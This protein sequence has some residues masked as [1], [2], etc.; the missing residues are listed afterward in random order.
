[1]FDYAGA[2]HV[3]TSYSYDGTTGLDEI[4]RAARRQGLDFIVVTDHFRMDARRDGWEGWH[5]DVLVI[6]GEEISPRHNHYLALNIETPVIHWRKKARAQD[7]IDEVNRQGGIG[8]IAHP[9]H[10][11][12]PGYGVKEYA[13]TDW[14]ATGYAGI[15]IWDFMTDWQEK[16][17]S[18]GAAVMAYLFPALNLSGPKQATLS[19]WDALCRTRKVA[20]YGEI[21]NHNS[22]KK[23]FGITFR[24]FPFDVAFNTIR[25]HVLLED[26]LSRDWQRARQQ[27]FDAL[28]A[29]R[30]YVA[31]ECWNKALGFVFEVREPQGAAVAVGGEY[32]RQPGSSIQVQLPRGASGRIRLMRDGA[33]SAE[34]VAGQLTLA[35]EAPGVYR[36][37]V[38]QKI[39]GRYRPWIY[40]NP[41][42]IK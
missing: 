4:I 31:Q 7:Y 18:L 26:K 27:I 28:T 10:T 2:F 22:R 30:L 9:D 37:E 19:R 3:H 32:S 6:V 41:I 14:S 8:L 29:C 5:D 23:V 16:L 20:G 13:W 35:L 15:S 25:T 39:Y 40:S 12:A 1:M 34:A 38:E 17:G 21:D 11:G 24:V 36:A 42:W 33:V